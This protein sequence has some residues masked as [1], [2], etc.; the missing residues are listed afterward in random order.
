[1]LKK[2]TCLGSFVVDLT[3]RVDHLPLP[4]E[5]VITDYFKMGPGGKGS[6]Q[7]VAAKRAGGNI[8]LMTK[9]GNDLL[10]QVAVENFRKEGFDEK[11]IVIDKS[12]FT[13]VALI[14]VD[15]NTSENSIAVAPGACEHINDDDIALLKPEIESCDIF[16]TQ[17][18]VNIDAVEKAVKIAHDN[19]KIIVFNT[20]PV[21]EIS[22]ELLSKAT[23]V[24]PNEIEASILTKVEVT[25][26]SSAGKAA[27]VFFDK[28]IP[29][30]V[31]T[32][33]KKGCYLN[34]GKVEEIIEPVELK[35]IDTTGAGDAFTGGLAV[36]LAE[37]KSLLNA[38]KFATCVAGLSTT[39]MGTA[40]SM[41]YRGEIDEL[42]KK[43]YGG[44]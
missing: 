2:I 41:P 44:L 36:A 4:G 14:N 35:T 15:K 37:G 31:I 19:K 43:A 29:N 9:V 11:Y 7:A 30:V 22:D 13:G 34:D 27:R 39:K 42:V 40:P 23:I 28:G 3:C 38:V 18:E 5:S 33:G 25:D 32:L 1:M 8:V 12:I 10:S 26:K 20:A 16:L 24:T 6:N 17:L 21:R